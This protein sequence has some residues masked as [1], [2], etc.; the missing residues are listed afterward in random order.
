MPKEHAILIPTVPDRI[1]A[2]LFDLDGVLTQTAKV[3]AAA[4]KQMFDAF[5]LDRSKRTGRAVPA[6]RDRRPT[7]PQHVDGKLRAGRRARVPGVARDRAAR[8]LAGRPADGAD[9]ARPGHAQE[10]PRPRAHPRARRGRVRGLGALR[11]GGARPA[12]CAR[13]WSRPAR[14]AARCWLAAGIEHLFEV[15]VDGVVAETP[16]ACAASRHRTCSSPPPPALGVEPAHS[17]V[18][19]DAVAGVRSGPGRRVWLGRRRRPRRARPTRC[20][21]A[22][23][24]MVVRDLGELLEDAMI[25]PGVFSVEP[26]AVA[27]PTAAARSAGPDRV[28]LRPVERAHRAARQPR[29]GRAARHPRHVPERVLRDAAAAVRRRRLRLSRSRASR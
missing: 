2:C 13:R 24:D 8:G 7:T 28:D 22:G 9:R 17:A 4:W 19:E 18:F 6:V 11:R 25:E 10:R 21:N 3:H 16:K 26:W 12:G 15:R 23:A 14:T 27:E 5:L 1:S 29:R 20:A